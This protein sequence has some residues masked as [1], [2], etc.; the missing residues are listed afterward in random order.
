MNR[1]EYERKVKEAMERTPV[2]T[3]LCIC[4]RSI[5]ENLS[6]KEPEAKY[7]MINVWAKNKDQKSNLIDLF[8]EVRS[9]YLDLEEED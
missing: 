9:L 8:N 1:K 3:T 5:A 7:T 6:I 4:T 2:E